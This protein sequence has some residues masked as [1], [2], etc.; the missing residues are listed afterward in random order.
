M[1]AVT[2][3]STE[4]Q[5]FIG[6]VFIPL[7]LPHDHGT[8]ADA[9]RVE[10]TP[11]IILLGPDGRE[12]HRM[13]G[14]LSPGDFLAGAKLG[15]A[16]SL[17]GAGNHGETIQ[18]LESLL[19]DYPESHAVPEAIYLVGLSRY[20]SSHKPRHLKEMYEELTS[21]FPGSEWTRRSFQYRLL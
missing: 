2:Y 7:R 14:F 9:L 21:K 15:L 17:E 19:Q 13:T 3:P 1:D 6:E 18:L 10:K 12:F 20:M 4:V 8:L 16:K 11:S 5:A